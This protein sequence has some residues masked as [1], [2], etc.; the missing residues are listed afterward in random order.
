MTGYAGPR[1]ELGPFYEKIFQRSLERGFERRVFHRVGPWPLLALVR[2]TEPSAPWIYLSAGIHGDEPAS[3]LGVLRAL[4]R[5]WLGR[6]FN[7]T[8]FPLLNPLGATLNQREGM[9][10]EDLNRDYLEPVTS[11]VRAHRAFLSARNQSYR[12]TLACHEDWECGGGYLYEL[13][14]LGSPSLCP[15]L[16]RAMEETCGIEKGDRIDGWPVRSPGV[17]RT[18]DNP[19]RRPRWPESIFLLARHTDLS[20]TVET[21][22]SLPLEVRTEAHARCIRLIQDIDDDLSLR[23]SKERF[24]ETLPEHG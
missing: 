18:P 9:R 4:A 15:G 3:S 12:V 22:S 1:L 6:R 21:P 14:P 23:L 2:E 8:V 20:Y 11:E 24:C 16:L 7:W 17:I 19:A 10:G 13:N 5:G